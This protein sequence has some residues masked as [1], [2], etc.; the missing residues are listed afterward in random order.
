MTL[1]KKKPKYVDAIQYNGTNNPFGV[2]K[3]FGGTDKKIRYIQDAD[4]PVNIGDYI[5]RGQDEL[6][7]YFVVEPENVFKNKFEEVQR[8]IFCEFCKEGSHSD[9]YIPNSTHPEWECSKGEFVWT[10]NE[11]EVT[12]DNDCGYYEPKN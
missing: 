10:D 9:K 5:V 12:E 2:I 6:S 8:C 4:I 1:Y 11:D 7:E 3:E